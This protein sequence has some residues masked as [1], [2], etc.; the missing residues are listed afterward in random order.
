MS[1]ASRV[2]MVS[3]A[4]RVGV[5]IYVTSISNL[6]YCVCDLHAGMTR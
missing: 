4:V 2:R 6:H 3:V 5:L 1:A